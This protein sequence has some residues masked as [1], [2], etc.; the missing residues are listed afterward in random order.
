MLTV[1]LI[2]LQTT[3]CHFLELAS[4]SCTL[5]QVRSLSNTRSSAILTALRAAP[6]PKVWHKMSDDISA[7]DQAAINNWSLLTQLV[8]AELLEEAPRIRDEL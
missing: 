2:L 5:F 1:Q 3:T 4:L 7:L 8:V 6:F